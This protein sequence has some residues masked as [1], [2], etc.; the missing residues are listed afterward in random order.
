[1][2]QTGLDVLMK[3]FMCCSFMAVLSAFDATPMVLLLLSLPLV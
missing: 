2:I 3:A 1:M